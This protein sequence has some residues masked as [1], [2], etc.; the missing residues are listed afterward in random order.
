MVGIDLPGWPQRL[1][2]LLG[3]LPSLPGVA[4]DRLQFL[5]RHPVREQH[6]DLSEEGLGAALGSFQ[7]AGSLRLSFC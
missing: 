2:L 4:L 1:P 6:Q 7:V 5:V 3:R